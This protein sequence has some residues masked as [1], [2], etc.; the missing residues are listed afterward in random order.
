MSSS[1]DARNQI[2]RVKRQTMRQDRVEVERRSRRLRMMIGVIAAAVIV[3]GLLIFF[4]R[5]QEEDTMAVAFDDIPSSGTVLGSLDAPVRIVEYADYQC[6]FCG[7]FER[8][9]VPLIVRDFVESGQVSLE[10]HPF[11]FLGGSDLETPGNESIQASEAAA[12]AMDQGKFWPYSHKL[13]DNQDGENQG[14]FSDEN[15]KAFASDIGLDTEAFN[16]CLDSDAHHQT[17]LDSYAS[18]QQAGISST[19]TILIN[20]EVVPYTSQGYELLKRQIEAAIAGAPL[21]ES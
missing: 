10:L 6:P 21:P 13:F 7:Q 4:N 17:A 20:G 8:E 15:L 18:A 19:P 11:P 12:C 1:R 3:A 5:P 9:V 2:R 14:A 16:A